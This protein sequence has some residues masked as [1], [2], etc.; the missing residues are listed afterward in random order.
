MKKKDWREL[1]KPPT[2]EED[3]VQAMFYVENI[4][5]VSSEAIF[6]IFRREG[7]VNIM[8]ELVRRSDEELRELF[9]GY[10]YATQAE[11]H[12]LMEWFY[13]YVNNVVPD[14]SPGHRDILY[15]EVLRWGERR[16]ILNEGEFL[17]VLW[18]EEGFKDAIT[19]FLNSLNHVNSFKCYYETL[20]AKEKVLN[21]VK[22]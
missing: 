20:R 16:Q 17:K 18:F 22:K 14:M 10:A 21:K 11:Q 6:E 1:L 8:E 5:M 3:F 13:E 15:R 7:I 12:Y 4:F 2:R 9:N 19:S